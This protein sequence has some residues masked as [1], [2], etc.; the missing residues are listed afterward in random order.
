M[1]KTTK[2]LSV[3]ILF[4]FSCIIYAI[5][6]EYAI[7]D[8]LFS[9]EVLSKN[10]DATVEVA[11]KILSGN[12]TERKIFSTTGTTLFSDDFEG[13]TSK[14][15]FVN[16]L[17]NEWF[18]GSAVN[19]GGTKALYVSNDK[20]ITNAYTD[21]SGTVIF[22]V[23]NPINIPTNT[24]EVVLSLDWR[25]EGEG[26]STLY[27]YGEIWII[28][29]TYKPALGTKI[30][31]SLSKGIL[32][33]DRMLKE[34]TFKNEKISLDLSGFAGKTVNIVVQWANDISGNYPPA[35][36]ID[37]FKLIIPDC[38]RIYGFNNTATTASSASFEWN[39][40]PI[41][42][43]IEI[44]HSISDVEPLGTTKGTIVSTGNTHTIN[45]LS[46]NQAYYVWQRSD[47]GSGVKGDWFGPI[48]IQ[49]N[50][51]TLPLPFEEGFDSYSTTI[52]CWR[53]NDVDK[54][55][56]SPT[57]DNI[58]R[59]TIVK[60]DVFEGDA[61]MYFNGGY[62]KDHNDW[63]ISPTFNFTGGMYKLTYYYK[64][65]SSYTND[66]EVLLS[67]KGTAVNSFTTVLVP[68]TAYNNTTYL[69]KEV[70]IKGITGD[71]NIAWHVNTKS[72][73]KIYID[74]VE[75]EAVSC[76]DI[77]TV[78]ILGSTDTSVEFSFVDQGNTEWEYW[79]Q[80]AGG[81]PPLSSGVSTTTK[82][83]VA[84][85]DADKNPLVDDTE[86]EIYMRAKCGTSANF[87]DWVGPFKFKTKCGL[88]TL[89]MSEG[90]DTT[91]SSVQCWSVDNSG[92]AANATSNAWYLYGGGVH[93]GD[94][95]MYYSGT[96]TAHD[97]YLISPK[98]KLQVGKL[99]KLSY[100]Y[101]TSSSY[102]NEFEV[103]ASKSGIKKTDFTDVLVTRE[104]YKN[105][106]YI[107]K[108]VYIQ[109]YNGTINVA[110]HVVGNKSNTIYIDT[111]SLEE[112]N[113]IEPTDLIANN[114]TTNSITLSWTDP[115]STS[116]EYYVQKD[117]G[118][119]PTGSGTATTTKTV[120]ATKDN[121][122]ANLS[123]DTKYEFYV[124]S[125][126]L[127]GSMSEWYGPV[128]F[129][130]LCGGQVLPL[131]ENFSTTS[132]TIN[133]WTVWDVNKDATSPLGSNLW[134]PITSGMY[135]GDQAMYF[136]GNSST[137]Q[138]NDWL[139]TPTYNF[140]KDGIYKLT[141]YYKTSSSYTNDFEVLLS[142]TGMS[143]SAFTTVLVPKTKTNTTTYLKKEVYIDNVV[144]NVNIA[145]RF[146]GMG[147]ATI[148]IGKVTLEKVGCVN[149]DT[150]Q[151]TGTTQ[152][153]VD[154]KWN[155]KTNTSWE[156]WIQPKGGNVP[157]G[158]GIVSTTN[159]VTATKDFAGNN[160]IPGTDYEF[161]V[162]AVCASGGNSSWE[163]PVGFYTKCTSY[164]LPFSESYNTSSPT[165]K[166]WEI[167][168][169]KGDATSPTGNNIWK[170]TSTG[171]Y[172]GDQA[173]Y[174]YGT[175]T[176]A[177]HDDWL[178]SPAITLGGKLYRITYYYKTTS[179]GDNDFELVAT[180]NGSNFT[181]GTVIDTKK[182][183]KETAYKKATVYVSGI[184]GDT[185]FG[186]HV[187][188]KGTTTI[189]I[190]SFSITEVGCKDPENITT[191]NITAN[192]AN[193]TWTDGVNTSWEYYVQDFGNG[194]PTGNGVAVTTP[195]VT[196]T[197][198]TGINTPLQPQT[199]YEYFVRSTC[200]V[201]NKGEWIGPFIIQTICN[202][203]QIPFT[204]DFEVNSQTVSCWQINDV[205]KDVTSNNLNIWKLSATGGV[206]GR[207]MSF[208][209][210]YDW[211]GDTTTH[212]D[213]LISP[214]MTL[215][216]NTNYILTFKYKT[217]SYT[218][219]ENRFA[220]KLSKTGT[221][222]AD[223]VTTLIPAKKY[224][225]GS[226][227]TESIYI[228]G[229]SG[230]VN[231]GWHV[232]GEDD[233][234]LY[235]DD[236]NVKV[237]NCIGPNKE[238]V[239][240]SNITSNSATIS[241]VDVNTANTAYNY[242]VQAAGGS[243][244]VG[245]GSNTNGK[246]V[247][248]NSLNSTGGGALQPDTEY[249]FYF[250][251]SCDTGKFSEWVGPIRFRTKC[252][253][254][255]LPIWDG[256]NTGSTYANC[257]TY[258][259]D[260]GAE[261]TLTSSGKWSMYN[262][263]WSAF[264]GD[265]SLY[266]YGGGSSTVNKD[267]AISPT[268][269]TVATKYYRLKYHY[270]GSTSYKGT[271]K[272]AYSTIGA[273]A[274][275][276][277]TVLLPTKVLDNGDYQEENIVFKGVA[278]NMNIGFLAEKPGYS[279]MYIDNLFIEE[280]QGCP[281]PSDLGAKDEQADN[282]TIFWDQKFEGSEWEYYVQ[283]SGGKTPAQNATGGVKVKTKQA[284]A[285]KDAKG[286]K[287]NN[288]T[289][290]EFY[291]RT[292]CSATTNS[293]WVGPFKFMTACGEF[294]PPFNEG[295]NEGSIS[296]RCWTIVDNNKDATSAT[297][298]NIWRTTKTVKYQG[299][300]AMEFVGGAGVNHDDWLI[301]PTFKL[302]ATK[303]YRMKYYYRTSGTVANVNE[304]EVLSSSKGIAV[305]DFKNVVKAKQ[306][307]ENTTVW[308]EEYRYVK[309]VGGSINFAFHVVS[310]GG[311]TIY[312]DEFS[313][314]EVVGCPEPID[315]GVSNVAEDKAT[316][317]WSD[318]FGATKF[319]Y[320]VQEQGKRAPRLNDSGTPVMAKSVVAVK[321]NTT[322]AALLP[323]TEYEFYVRTNCGN[324]AFSIWNG[325]FKFRTNCGIY[326][327]PFIETF[328]TNSTSVKCWTILD[329]ANDGSQGGNVW[330][331]SKSSPFEGDGHAWFEGSAKKRHNDWLISPA[332]ELDGGQYVL[333]YRY[334][335]IAT[336]N[337]E[338]EVMLST[339]GAIP[340]SFTK[341]LVA[342]KYYQNGGY[343]EEVV[344]FDNV[345]GAA[346]IGWHVTTNGATTVMIDKVE[347]KKV[348][349][350]PEPHNLEIVKQTGNSI[351]I[352]WEQAG[353]SKTWEV[354]YVQE[355]ED[356]PK[357]PAQV[358]TVTGTP[359]TTIT[360]LQGGSRYTIYVRAI[361][362]DGKSLSEWSSG[363]DTYTL[364]GAN[365]DCGGAIKVTANTNLDDCK[366]VFKGVTTGITKSKTV[367]PQCWP[368]KS[369]DDLWF[370]YTPKN[371]INSFKLNNI[372]NLKTG[373]AES[374][375]F[376]LA[377][378]DVDCNVIDKTAKWCT[379]ITSD[380]SIGYT[381]KDMIPNKKYLIRIAYEPK[382]DVSHAFDLCIGSHNGKHLEVIPSQPAEPGNPD[383]DDFI[384]DPTKPYTVDK[385]VKNVL[386]KSNCKLVT[387]V[388]YQNG[389]GSAKAMG[390]NTL[391]YFNKGQ[392]DFPFDEG[393]V[394]STNEVQFVPGPYRGYGSG[395]NRGA[396]NE[397]WRGDKDI[398]DAINDAGGHKVE[399]KR[400]TQLEFDFVPIKELLKFEYLF[401]SNS[402]H[403]GCMEQCNVGALFAAWLVDTE[404]GKGVNLAKINN[405]DLPISIKS[406][407]DEKKAPGCNVSSYPELFDKYYG[408]VDSYTG[409]SNGV[410]AWI[411]FVGTTK[412]MG[413]DEVIVVP[414]RKYHIKLAVMD[415][416]TTV[417]HSSVAFFK[418]G[419]FDLGNLD[420]GADLTI[421]NNNAICNT[422]SK[423][424]KTGLGEGPNVDI[425]WFKD[426]VEIPNEKKPDL[427]INETGNYRVEA[428]YKD[429]KC[430][431][432]GEIKAEIYPAI[433]SIVKSPTAR[434]ICKHSLL[435]QPVGLDKA[436]EEMFEGV[437][438]LNY[439]VR[440][441][442]TEEDE[443]YSKNAIE[444]FKE[445]AVKPENDNSIVYIRVED[446]RS[447]CSE[448]FKLKITLQEGE[449]P[450]TPKD[451]V[452]CDSYA[453]PDL[454]ANQKYYSQAGG[455]GENYANGHVFKA[456]EYDVYILQDNGNNGCYEE[457]KF[458]VEV[459][460]KQLAQQL[461]DQTLSCELYTLKDLKDGSKYYT[462]VNG[463]RIELQPGT[464]ITTTN[465]KVYVVVTSKNGVC[466]DET[467]FMIRYEDCPIPK[468]FSPNG[469]GVNDVFDLSA[470][471]ATSVKI[472]NRNGVEVYTF[473]GIY[474]NQW[475]G[476]DKSNKDL[477]SGTYYYV[478]E[479][480]G[481]TR[482]GWVQ[483]NR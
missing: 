30:T 96:A 476:K 3:L 76:Y 194:L 200:D 437:D 363:K 11:D 421:E 155:D 39:A 309:G 124:R 369:L 163:G 352:K 180:T 461:E 17:E 130:T 447:G 362:E 270:K 392:T 237:A 41:G 141:Y 478:I 192:S 303:V 331:F 113:C 64:A 353:T 330:Q 342:K 380:S 411:D 283:P 234:E 301:T 106:S 427:K 220:V 374:T 453:L 375:K 34:S 324:D 136:Y 173:M 63:L 208:V 75:L 469:D 397:R 444:N 19:N 129:R 448:V 429:I 100:Y 359:S 189:Y 454:P 256:F 466:Y 420:L 413:S 102:D 53:V 320:F 28:P 471:G 341:T 360:N 406:I 115:I 253:I 350:C 65:Q 388:K 393:I 105:S 154:L 462:E 162:R 269:T 452:A 31:T 302:D 109:G 40:L 308:K 50:C 310:K 14:W 153:S 458:K 463:N 271:L 284:K 104:V 117:G 35:L 52:D 288:N 382:K 265:G 455:K 216:P 42:K 481:K 387:N 206:K 62:N 274:T 128:K 167:V 174:F 450:T 69:K 21:K 95:V 210:Y 190:D 435:P 403:T 438:K 290:Y 293:I 345:K 202:I 152:N 205:N 223:F 60:A 405:T 134:R 372:I 88:Q 179:S 445:Y 73:A 172:E 244:P 404:T 230:D 144:G 457:T 158:K 204:E 460:A 111:V 279:S 312:I 116:W 349:T 482:T 58:W 296:L 275:G 379:T 78:D 218:Y 424:I 184:T 236:V 417:S 328:N 414:G 418:A 23:S 264:E 370:E 161:Y 258:V 186:F 332:V 72:Y 464:M 188:G 368:N 398:N 168:D 254:V 289:E 281:E 182:K 196:L 212:N 79:I 385:L 316:L 18:I 27:D 145:W 378:Y 149:P 59:T 319:E 233:M 326:K 235:I 139:I 282:A 2:V 46:S 15:T 138:H 306:V 440:A 120:T 185:R 68:K 268:F 419:S 313:L 384:P 219:D 439:N 291:V 147:Y 45:G 402:Y 148:Y 436:I 92:K 225:T 266:F 13:T 255:T 43:G 227:V 29:D 338:F 355:G 51:N 292:V 114:N 390:Y 321:D 248:V 33:K 278:G 246:T 25:C 472:F 394:L 66:F 187:N 238:D 26:T 70:Y 272:V 74:S 98:Y 412:A 407:R 198:L 383:S 169:V 140:V 195:S 366:V 146:N 327:T 329:L 211:F 207:C 81:A 430:P 171:T 86:Y 229:I 465:T 48:K 91:S 121:A 470:H 259:N 215:L 57:G 441:Y 10:K 82:K 431:I 54:D 395:N 322:R 480:F 449:K 409:F 354:V 157:T 356:A 252:G 334:K 267:W 483:L 84:T 367:E 343:V 165:V 108:D 428:F 373:M 416:C 178:V 299:S 297:S 304:F 243:A 285:D 122:G 432:K 9:T 357:Q 125:K 67:N 479:A 199:L 336:R 474:T 119:K 203:V 347:L 213:W 38:T 118:A 177:V 351:D 183:I 298:T 135:E 133:C 12:S 164:N 4:V 391:G 151:V 346:N 89:P 1:S 181:G 240:V 325:P 335:T 232:T 87:N 295:F 61:A 333:K 364:V 426:N 221:K 22:A 93:Q 8:Y 473:K 142:N 80:D 400:V 314:E 318:D 55:A 305:A 276:M 217:T 344:F 24:T 250:R 37:N 251:S 201:N 249:D 77:E 85:N 277:T 231:I 239:T 348:L 422:E 176:P 262:S 5:N 381:I 377:I 396:N 423:T 107:K 451:V 376:Y 467:S 110:W 170:T 401:A 415:F 94:K 226:Y 224:T 315:L 307:Y 175:S 101:K 44:Y 49:T 126:C 137:I 127:N 228:K 97:E 443:I 32:L 257:W 47:C 433:S 358:I 222:P 112:A 300:Q 143:E 408:G 209:G 20:G 36:A 260:K 241:W 456:G 131:I 287:L 475:T 150:L 389:D 90:F 71:V 242:F 294:N 99:Y 361:C 247:N 261:S 273:K 446:V 56:T 410:G 477:P 317:S 337:N 280:V 263:T 434:T 103:V 399:N 311:T 123:A 340:A 191:S 245:G 166:C 132:T 156:Y 339:A 160:L 371:A 6:R 197:Q 193:V 386:V 323:N 214:T 286:N 83:I 425:K 468:G 459:T 159:P 16:S 442:E 365:D 7:S